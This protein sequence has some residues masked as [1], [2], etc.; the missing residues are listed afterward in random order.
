MHSN[1]QRITDTVEGETQ[2]Y[3]HKF[4]N[5]EQ[6][7]KD[8]SQGG[9]F[10]QIE[11]MVAEVRRLTQLN[12]KYEMRYFLLSL[13]LE[14][15]SRIISD[16]ITEIE[17]YRSSLLRKDA[18]HA[19][20]LERIR[21]EETSKI[22][23]ALF[24][25]FEGVKQQYLAEKLKLDR[26]CGDLQNEIDS[27]SLENSDLKGKI[28]QLLESITNLKLKLEDSNT[29]MKV[30]DNKKDLEISKIRAEQQHL[31]RDLENR[32][33]AESEALLRQMTEDKY[34]EIS[35]LKGSFE[36]EFNEEIQRRD[37]KITSLNAENNQNLIK[38]QELQSEIGGFKSLFQSKERECDEL[39]LLMNNHRSDLASQISQL[40][41]ELASK[42]RAAQEKLIEVA[43]KTAC[44]REK[45]NQELAAKCEKITRLEN[46]L[47]ELESEVFKSN[48]TKGGLK[49]ENEF[50]KQEVQ[51][52]QNERF[53]EV[54]SV[55]E[56][57]TVTVEEKDNEI[58]SLLSQIANLHEMYQNKLNLEQ[59]RCNDL[60]SENEHLQRENHNLG[61]LSDTRKR[62][63]EDWCRKYKDYLTPDE[64][65][66][67]KAELN[68]LRT[69]NMGFEEEN[70]RYKREVTRLNERL[71][72]L[73]AESESKSEDIQNLNDHL[74]KRAD[75]ITSLQEE[76]DE[77]ISRLRANL[78]SKESNEAERMVHHE[79]EIKYKHENEQLKEQRDAYK[80][81]YEDS[82]TE[83]AK[84]NQKYTENLSKTEEHLA[85]MKNGTQTTSHMVRTSQMITKTQLD[86]SLQPL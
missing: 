67:A 61:T 34:R 32:Q 36:Q 54:K 49:E 11:A 63:I 52:V 56:H 27:K 2:I 74:R 45:A 83:L 38:M 19:R 1:L 13:E 47:M 16:Y 68:Q 69:A 31:L 22:K 4:S 3:K 48:Q 46:K 44:E 85:K 79:I 53:Q 70:L 78:S 25:E 82:L 64:A 75:L 29:L 35:L 42:G 72:A 50:L 43:S 37:I 57:L 84:V 60:S 66:K 26:R 7:L 86:S 28:S 14:R 15:R 21:D 8:L 20:E 30:N 10:Q 24:L 59:K 9:L 58:T 81:K 41:Q 71:K 40:E 12:E 77:L 62:E 39:R 5:L 33:R 55:E 17:S 80:Q 18:E 23:K 51:R 76:K 73:D 6:S 65:T